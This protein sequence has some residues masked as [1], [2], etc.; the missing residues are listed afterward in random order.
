[1]ID[2]H[3]IDMR[4]TYQ[5]DL[6][7]IEESAKRTYGEAKCFFRKEELY[8][9]DIQR[10]LETGEL[11]LVEDIYDEVHASASGLA[12]CCEMY[13]KALYIYENK[14]SNLSIEDIWNKLK[15]PEYKTDENGRL[16]YRTSNGIITYPK[17][18]SN[19]NVML[20]SNGN[21]IYTDDQNNIYNPNNRGSKIKMNGHDLDRLIKLLSDESQMLLEVRICTIP[22]EKTSTKSNKVVSIIDILRDKKII[23]LSNK[24]TETNYY[25]WVETHRKAFE[26]A[27]YSGQID[28]DVNIEFLY[29]LATQLKA[30]VQYKMKPTQ[31]QIFNVTDEELK[32]LPKEIQ[33]LF[34]FDKKLVSQDLIKLVANNESVKSKLVYL[35][36]NDYIKYL[37]GVKASNFY[38]LLNQ[39]ELNE[40][41]YVIH[42]CK[43]FG[44]YKNSLLN[45]YSCSKISTNSIITL[46][47]DTKS[48][49][50]IQFNSEIV[51]MIANSIAYKFN[52]N[53]SYLKQE[54]IKEK[55]LN[56]NMKFKENEN[57]Y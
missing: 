26:E 46:C 19:N 49:L 3:S 13:L 52:H 45:I 43:N 38:N 1:M 6:T 17:Y 53:Y 34:E 56:L 57:E 23:S 44:T 36:S 42:L 11:R 39:F 48:E 32:S 35:I 4:N 55:L 50:N 2:A 25:S 7:D 5:P 29:H 27:R 12:E 31:E 41:M 15:T 16:I 9:N 21:E 33:E 51:N 14:N 30:V 28:S 8:L 47:L 54:N 37:T 24:M 10:R 18:D 20:D 22:M 40:L